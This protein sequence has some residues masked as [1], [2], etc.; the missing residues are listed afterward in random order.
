MIRVHCEVMAEV[1]TEIA[2]DYYPSIVW[3][4]PEPEEIVEVVAPDQV[5]SQVELF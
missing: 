1:M 3:L 4:A 5:P 2:E